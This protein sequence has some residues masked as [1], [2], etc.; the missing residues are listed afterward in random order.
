MSDC[1]TCKGTG[2]VMGYGYRSDGKGGLIEYERIM[3]CN[4]C[5]TERCLSMEERAEIMKEIR[6]EDDDS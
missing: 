5:Q 3:A 2:S 6:R 4:D 1:K